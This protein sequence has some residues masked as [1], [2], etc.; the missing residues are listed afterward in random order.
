VVDTFARAIETTRRRE[1]AVDPLQI[2][3]IGDRDETDDYDETGDANE[4][5][6]YNETEDCGS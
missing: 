4:T 6:D 3:A 2:L 5:D 1:F